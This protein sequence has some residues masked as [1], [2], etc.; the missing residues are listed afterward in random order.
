[1]NPVP[2]IVTV[3]PTEPEVSDRDDITG[4][5]NTLNAL[6]LSILSAGLITLIKPV[7]APVGTEVLIVVLF[8]IVNGADIPLNFTPVAHVN[9]VPVMVTA[10]PNVPLAGE[11]EAIVGAGITVKLFTLVP[12]PNGF[13]TDTVPVVAPIGTVVV[14]VVSFTTVK[15]N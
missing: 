8:T 11:K 10:V 9:P 4:I 1:L 6:I 15:I 14:I 13:V 2:V 7:D 12:V 5:P 3:E